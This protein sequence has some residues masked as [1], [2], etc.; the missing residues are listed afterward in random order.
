M[1]DTLYKTYV[2]KCRKGYVGDFAKEYWTEQDHKE[3]ND[4]VAQ[5]RADGTLGEEFEIE[6]KILH[7]PLFD[8]I[9]IP[10]KSSY[11]FDIID[12]NNNG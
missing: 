12:F 9:K 8:E 2:I 7:N 3:H 10:V 5:C 11:K 4:F 1:E 6:M